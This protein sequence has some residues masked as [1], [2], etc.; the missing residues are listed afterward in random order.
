MLIWLVFMLLGAVP[1][2]QKKFICMGALSIM[3][4]QTT[5]GLC[6]PVNDLAHSGGGSARTMLS[7]ILLCRILRRQD[8]PTAHPRHGS[9]QARQR[10]TGGAI[11]TDGGGS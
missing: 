7:L 1:E 3:C 4:K 10:Q 6:F 2:R 8:R 9:M 5:A 11:P